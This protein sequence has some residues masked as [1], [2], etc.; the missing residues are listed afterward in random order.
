MSAYRFLVYWW[1]DAVRT[2][3]GDYG[4]DAI[5]DTAA[6]NNAHTLFAEEIELADQS[7]ILDGAGR[8]VWSNE[9]PP[10]RQSG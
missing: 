6:I 10:S 3:G 8:S 1:L 7:E 4:F 5:S 9:W 2:I